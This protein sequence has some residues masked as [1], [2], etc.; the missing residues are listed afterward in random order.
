MKMN[1][2]IC[3]LMDEMCQRV[4][5]EGYTQEIASEYQVKVNEEINLKWKKV[6]LNLKY[7]IKVDDILK[8]LE[9]EYTK[10]DE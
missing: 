8:E 4:D 6:L 9:W 10:L 7:P 5:E 1:N 2:K 3:A